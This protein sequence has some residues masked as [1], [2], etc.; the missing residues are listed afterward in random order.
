MFLFVD[1]LF[2]GKCHTVITV[3]APLQRQLPLNFGQMIPFVAVTKCLCFPVQTK[4]RI[5]LQEGASGKL[6]P[7]IQG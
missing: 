1:E 6:L 5:L 2:E 3:T 7:P 4:Q